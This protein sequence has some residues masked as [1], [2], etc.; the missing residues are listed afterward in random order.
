MPQNALFFP[1]R[2]GRH[3]LAHRVVLAP[4]TRT[5]ADETSLAPTAMTAE[6]Y[7]QRASA[8][9]LLITEADHISPEAT[10]VWTIYSAVRA[11]GGQVPGIWTDA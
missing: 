6:Y 11:G 8:G 1:H 2:F 7:A 5:R 3:Q 10:P 9:G 4:M